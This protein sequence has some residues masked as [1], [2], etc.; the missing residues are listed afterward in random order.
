MPQGRLGENF[1]QENFIKS[2]DLEMMEIEQTQMMENTTSNI[3]LNDSR[4]S[5]KSNLVYP[6]IPPGSNIRP[7]FETTNTN[8][9]TSQDDGN[10][11]LSLPNPQSFKESW[12]KSKT[13]VIPNLF[14]QAQ[15]ENLHSFYYNKPKDWWDLILYPDPYFNYEQSN[16]ENPGYYHMYKT[17]DNDPSI[18]KRENYI[19]NLNNE[20]TFSYMYRRTGDQPD[21]F[22]P[23]L[24]IFK[25]KKFTDYISLITGY[26]N[27]EYSEGHTFVSC[28]ESGHFNGPHTD[29][30]NGRVAFVFH[31]SKDWLPGYGGLFLRMNWDWKTINKAISPPFN[32]LTMFD[33][34]GGA[35]HLVTEIAQGVNN[36]RISFT[37]WYQ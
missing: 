36:K 26:Q 32:S 35:P 33:V 14:P 30:A 8:K 27:L 18:P 10:F 37:G 5:P 12:E 25:S 31:I 11:N 24:D 13:I 21:K 19:R 6:Q 23:Y 29:G 34:E 1:S 16:V 9:L 22:H 4:Y 7:F 2:I 3:N 28:Y 20:G 15:A 17:K